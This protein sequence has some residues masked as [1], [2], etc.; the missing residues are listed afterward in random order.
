MDKSE[1]SNENLNDR[2]FACWFTAFLKSNQIKRAVLKMSSILDNLFWNK[3]YG[4][5][6]QK[7]NFQ[8]LW[9]VYWL[10]SSSDLALLRWA[11]TSSYQRTHHSICIPESPYVFHIA[12]HWRSS[13]GRWGSQAPS[14]T[15]VATVFPYMVKSTRCPPKSRLWAHS[16]LKAFHGKYALC[17][18]SRAM[19]ETI[20]D[21]S[22]LNE[23]INLQILELMRSAS[24]FFSVFFKKIYKKGI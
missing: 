17:W 14:S 6:F 5:Q 9:V 16:N 20:I 19:S 3:G 23:M 18:T 10:N 8:T 13:G 15:C 12:I 21:F 1:R 4:L 11:T 2:N 22:L 7:H 24:K